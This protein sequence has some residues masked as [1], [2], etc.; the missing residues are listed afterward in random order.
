[1]TLK[2][3]LMLLILTAGF[4]VNVQAQLKNRLQPGKMYEAGEKI[5]APR[6][7]F[8][9]VVP[10][11]WEG[12]LPREEEI[13]LLVPIGE[14]GGEVFT[15][16]NFQKDLETIRESWSK[17]VSLSET[18]MIKP[19]GKIETS[20]NM[21]T[22]E[23]VPSGEAVNKGYKGFAA[24]VCS[25]YGHCVTCLGIGPVQFYDQVQ[26]AVRSF[27]GGATFTEPS[28]VSLYADF[29]WKEFLAGKMLISYAAIETASG[30]GEKE[31]VVH[32]CS[33]GTFKAN[34]KKKGVMKQMNAKYKGKQSGTWS[35]SSIGDTGMLKL[36]FKKLP[37]VELPLLIKDERIFINDERYF[38]GTSD[39]CK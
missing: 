3:T 35:T 23:V 17:G 28:T 39:A 21:I 8:N 10:E 29:D 6:Y 31:N 27:L 11:G 4:C 14:I 25:P 30:S 5:Y 1:M 15:F 38:A 34:L 20:G 7:G 18:I 12:T 19:A 26:R 33:D 37:E 9:S 13:F 16:V 24:A 36:T 22:A 2:T 32:L